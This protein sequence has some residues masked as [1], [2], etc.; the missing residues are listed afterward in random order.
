[1][2]TTLDLSK[3]I[4]AAKILRAQIADLAAG[5][6]DF[7]R[8]VIEGET[9][10]REIIAGLVA[11]EAEDL[12]VIEGLDALGKRLDDRKDRIK[13]RVAT[14]RALIASGMEIGA[15]DKLETPAGTVSVKTVPPSMRVIE[16]ADIPARFWKPQPPK[17]DKKELLAALKAKEPIP[18]AELSNGGR[19]IQIRR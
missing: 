13:A 1:M 14:R 7:I 9:N 5:D 17:L 15:I 6:E 10:L 3:E 18:G 8:D 2:T 11:S 19:T 4:E 16:E 12:A